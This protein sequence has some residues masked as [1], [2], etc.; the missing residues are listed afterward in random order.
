MNLV[1][2]YF[3]QDNSYFSYLR[4]VVSF[5]AP[6]TIN[7]ALSGTLL[8]LLIDYQTAEEEGC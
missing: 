1:M 6:M 2:D 5:S 8:H 3:V 7:S 4:G